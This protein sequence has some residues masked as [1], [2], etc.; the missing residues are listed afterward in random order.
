MG[1][2][3]EVSNLRKE[4]QELAKE[5]P[6]RHL[7]S[8]VEVNEKGKVVGGSSN[9]FSDNQEEAEAAMHANM[10]KQANFTTQ[11]THRVS[12]SLSD[13]K[14]TWNIMFG[15]AILYLSC[16]TTLLFQKDVSI[17]MHKGSMQEWKGISWWLLTY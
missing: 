5:Y 17:S 15:R 8:V 1:K 2:S 6:I 12:S 10:F 13:A 7:L 9:L 16:P 3:P 4:V 11:F 14:L